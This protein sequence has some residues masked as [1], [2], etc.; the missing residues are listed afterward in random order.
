MNLNLNPDIEARLL[1]LAEASG[2]SVE[3]FLRRVVEEK[4]GITQLQRLSPDEWETQFDEWADSLPERPL[5]PDEAL[6]RENLYPD[7]W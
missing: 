5:I 2:V 7:R 4:N 6:R 1:A 3:D